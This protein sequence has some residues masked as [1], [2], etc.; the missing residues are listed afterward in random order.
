MRLRAAG[1]E[2]IELG[3]RFAN[4]PEIRPNLRFTRPTSREKE[5]AF[6]RANP[7]DSSI[8]FVIV[9][10]DGAEAVG[11]VGLHAIHPE[12]RHAEL[13]IGISGAEHRGR[14]LGE[15]AIR[16]VLA[17]AFRELGLHRVYLWVKDF[18]PSKS[19]YARL[20]F[21]EEGRARAHEWQKGGWHDLLLMGVLRHE[22]EAETPGE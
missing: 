3:L 5:F 12:N 18:N 21:R 2:D 19:L 9:P 15:E 20:G 8:V 13:G 7:T 16:L 4:D 6:L 10:R 17:Y 1:E 22:W 11:F 14:G